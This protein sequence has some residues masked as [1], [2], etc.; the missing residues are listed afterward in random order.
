[1]RPAIAGAHLVFHPGATGVTLAG[2]SPVAAE[3]DNLAPCERWLPREAGGWTVLPAAVGASKETIANEA[4]QLCARWQ[5]ALACSRAMKPPALLAAGPD[6]VVAVLSQA[7]SPAL[8]RIVV[9]NARMAAALR[10]AFPDVAARIETDLS[11]RSL[12]SGHGVE[13][14][15]EALLSPV[16]KLQCGGTVFIEKTAAVVA[17][18]VDAGAADEGGREATALAVNREAADVIAREIGLRDVAGHVVIDFVP[19]RRRDNERKLL[20][21]LTRALA[22]HCLT[23]DLA[24]FTRLGLVEFTR[25]RSGPSLPETMLASCPACEGRG[26]VTSPLTV[27]LKSLREVIAEDRASPGRAWGIEAAPEVIAVFGAVATDALR[28]TEARLG[29]PLKLYASTLCAP[30]IYKVVTARDRE[31]EP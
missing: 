11:C 12:F 26:R 4:R 28:E 14:Q 16:I 19:M 9:D 15:I 25:R 31:R 24:G 13:E 6:P 10:L 8:V 27:A 1:M 21:R 29:R 22:R 30:D 20:R 5:E 18:D 7:F 23:V 3:R 2:G 17:I